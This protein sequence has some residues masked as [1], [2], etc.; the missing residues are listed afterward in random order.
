VETDDEKSKKPVEVNTG[1][2][3]FAVMREAAH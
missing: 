2:N 1:K 3:L